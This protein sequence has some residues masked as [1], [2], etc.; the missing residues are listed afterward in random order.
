MDIP[1]RHIDPCLLTSQ[2]TDEGVR[3]HLHALR[4][5]GHLRKKSWTLEMTAD[6]AIT[7][8]KGSALL[9]YLSRTQIIHYRET[10]LATN[11]LNTLQDKGLALAGCCDISRLA[12]RLC[13]SSGLSDSADLDDLAALHAIPL[14]ERIAAETDM[15]ARSRVLHRIWCDTIR[16]A[17]NYAHQIDTAPSL[18]WRDTAGVIAPEHGL[19]LPAPVLPVLAEPPGG[20]RMTPWGQEEA[21]E[22]ALLFAEG[23]GLDDLSQLLRRSPRAIKARLMLDGILTEA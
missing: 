14:S 4:R 13:R 17:L 23:A 5:N 1:A 18:G 16:L 12:A 15:V 7:L 3:L 10:A 8:P 21:A 9:R 2:I 19:P 22:V 11:L 6:G 20:W